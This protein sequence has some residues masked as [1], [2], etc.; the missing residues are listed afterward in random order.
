MKFKEYVLNESLES[1]PDSKANLIVKNVVAACKDISKLNSTGY[2]FINLANG[3]IA[4]YNLEGFKGYYS[5]EGNL[6]QD[7]LQN[8]SS[9]Q[10]SNFREGER[11]YDYYMKKKE[12]YNKIVDQLK[13]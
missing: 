3:F 4:H 12:I 11:D 13:G 6:K 9:N 8:Q 5:D 10:W 2:K 7:I 1:I